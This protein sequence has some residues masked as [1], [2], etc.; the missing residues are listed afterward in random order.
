MILQQLNHDCWTIR[1]LLKVDIFRFSSCQHNDR[2][3]KEGIFTR[4]SE[5]QPCAVNMNNVLV[6]SIPLYTSFIVE[7]SPATNVGMQKGETV[8]EGA[9][10]FI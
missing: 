6:P 10:T 5:S 3:R 9:N 4:E 8:P 7:I 2:E 1:P